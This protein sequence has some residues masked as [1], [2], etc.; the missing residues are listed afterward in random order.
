M[1]NRRFPILDDGEEPNPLDVLYAFLIALGILSS[2][3]YKIF[4]Q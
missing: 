2:I 1:P 4:A 3:I